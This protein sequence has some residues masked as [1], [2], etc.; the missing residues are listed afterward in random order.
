[1]TSRVVA[2]IIIALLSIYCVS[3]VVGYFYNVSITFP[4]FISD[5]HHVPEHRLQGIR[6]SL[7]TTFV[8]FSIRYFFV[9]SVKLYPVQV[10]GI[11][12]LNL[13]IVSTLVFYFK[14]VDPTEY[15]LLIFYLPASIILYYAG[16]P[17]MIKRIFKRK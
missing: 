17:E 4:F 12:L 14:G 8:Y 9:G 2:K 16:K 6:L 15:L 1:M 7:L 10:M 11:I 3:V 5:G 13:T